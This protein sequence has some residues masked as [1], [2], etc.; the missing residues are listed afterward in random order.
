MSRLGMYVLLGVLT[1]LLA[2]CPVFSFNVPPSIPVEYKSS[3]V[4]SSI[5]LTS[6]RATVDTIRY[7]GTKENG[8]SESVSFS[9]SETVRIPDPNPSPNSTWYLMSGG[10]QGIGANIPVDLTWHCQPGKEPVSVQFNH[11]NS[12]SGSKKGLTI[13]EDASLPEGFRIEVTEFPQ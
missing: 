1:L 4:C 3:G 2:A 6:N 12:T 8:R 13:T 9:P 7:W 5:E 10:S 11:V